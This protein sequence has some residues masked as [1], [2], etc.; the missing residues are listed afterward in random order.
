MRI[1]QIASPRPLSN[2]YGFDRGTPIDRI[3]IEQF[4]ERH[5]ADIRGRVLEVGDDRYSRRFGGER[6]ARQDVL[7]VHSD[8]PAATIVGDLA[9]A[10][11]L[12]ENSFDCVILT[13]T[14]QYVFDLRAAVSNLR[15]ALRPGG[16]ALITVPAIA[17]MCEDEWLKGHYWLF[18]A[19]SVERLLA[20]GFGNDKVDVECLGNLYAA[21]AFL[22][23][24][25]AEEMSRRKLRQVDHAYPVTIAARAVA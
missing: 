5:S 24:A 13:Q 7:H 10:N 25:A 23:G 20:A 18:T 4:L 19:A 17:P 15:R 21:T 8:N 14:L 6:I 1:G 2:C 16:V 11:T 22:H 12:P 9:D 3:Y